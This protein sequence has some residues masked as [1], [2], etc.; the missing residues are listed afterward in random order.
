MCTAITYHTKDS[1]FGR[2]LDLEYSYNEAVTVTPRNFPFKF[3]SG[4]VI[5][6]HFAMIG[7]AFVANGYPLYY[8]A[9]NEEGLAMAGLN[10][11]ENA[12]Y[13]NEKKTDRDNIATFEFIPWILS[14]CKNLADAKKKL[15]RINLTNE[16]FSEDLKPASLHWIIADK[17]SSIVVEAMAD[18][19]KIYDNPIGIMTNSPPFD[20]MMQ[21]LSGF[22]DLSADKSQNRL[23]P[24]VDL[25]VY[26]QGMA[27]MGLPG[28]WSSASRFV[29]AAFVKAN[30]VSQ[31][32]ENARVGQ[33]FHILSSVEMPRGCV[34]M[35]DGKNDITV[36]S[37]CCNQHKGIYYYSAYTNRQINAVDMHKENLSSDTLISYPLKIDENIFFHN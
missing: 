4:E 24:D 27:A 31:D 33:F 28:D 18:G 32:T 23:A 20:F 15:A 17:D 26:C 36:Y 21:Y 5:S 7:V 11:P 3:R 29:R 2:N 16:A 14:D 6:S 10:F 30:S 34:R 9:V 35:D 37:S 19:M 8:D 1:Y 13:S 25:P 12:R 22:R